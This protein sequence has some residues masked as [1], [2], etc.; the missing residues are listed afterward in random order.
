M[1]DSLLLVVDQT[2]VKLRH[3]LVFFQLYLLLERAQL[4]VQ[5]SLDLGMSILIVKFH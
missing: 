4:L 2:H 1:K 3:L 5:L